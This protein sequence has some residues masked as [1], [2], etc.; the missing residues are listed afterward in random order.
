[1]TLVV[2]AFQLLCLSDSEVQVFKAI[3]EVSN[4]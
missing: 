1:M 3:L 4:H 2:I